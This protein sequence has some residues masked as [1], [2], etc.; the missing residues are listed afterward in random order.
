VAALPNVTCL[1]EHE[2]RGLVASTDRARVG[3]VRVA[4]RGD[5]AGREL[6]ASL[7]VD[8]SGRG[9]RGLQWLE[10]LGYAKPGES[11]VT[12][13]VS[14]ATRL[15]RR[16]PADLDGAKALLIFPAPPGRRMGAALPI[17]GDRWLVTL[18]GMLGEQ[19]PAD[20]DGFVQYA[21]TLPAPDIHNLI[22]GVAPASDIVCYRFPAHLRRHYERMPRLPAGFIAIGDAVCS[23]NPIYG[24]GMTVSAI[25]AMALD[26]SLKAARQGESPDDFQRRFFGA[27]AE[28]VDV[29][30]T[31]AVGEDLRYPEVEGPRPPSMAVINRYV[32]LVHR[33]ATR[34]AA[35][36]HAFLTVQNML[37]PPAELFQEARS[38]GMRS[39]RERGLEKV[40]Q[41]LISADEFQRGNF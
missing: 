26:E 32:A 41:G 33:A 13:N 8:A 37:A 34:D 23:F 22:R 19:P 30:W 15:F 28:V 14:Y 24:Q 35:V 20:G 7:V 36:A 2:A 16:S 3:G 29:P 4:A 6:A 18:G 39:M 40:R 21:A 9:S 27:I 38:G 10:A 5:R 11:K 17:E 1:H 12:V 31:L 25:E